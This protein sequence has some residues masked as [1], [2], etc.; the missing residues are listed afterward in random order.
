MEISKR[1]FALTP[2]HLRYARQLGVRKIIGY[3]DQEEG[4]EAFDF[5]RLVQAKRLV[6]SYGLEYA[7]VGWPPQVLM[8]QIVQAGPDCDTAIERFCDCITNMGKA[9]IPILCY[10]FGL[11]WGAWRAGLNGGGHAATQE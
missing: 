7:A 11:N 6:E 1:V 9:G 2:E 4:V 3:L 5:I 8:D 10:A